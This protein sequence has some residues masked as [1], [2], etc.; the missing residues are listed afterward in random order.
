MTNIVTS[1]LAIWVVYDHPKDFP[2]YFIARR[3]LNDTPTDSLV[4]CSDL[5]LLRGQLEEMGL[6][7]VQPLEGDDA[8]ILETWL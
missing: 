2:D 1:Q 5:D 3:W 7:Q 4:M 8:V 6:V